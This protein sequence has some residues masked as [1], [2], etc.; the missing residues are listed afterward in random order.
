VRCAASGANG[1]MPHL[2]STIAPG[3]IQDNETG[4]VWTQAS[5]T[6]MLAQAAAVS[7]C[8]GLALNGHTWG[9]PSIKELA[10]TVDETPPITKVSPAIDTT[11]FPDTPANG[12]YMSSSTHGAMPQVATYT[13]GIVTPYSHPTGLVRCVR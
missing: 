2:Y 6:T 5:S 11:V 10:T 8:T 3:E 9:L 7:Y 4:L 1:P 12:V 13:D